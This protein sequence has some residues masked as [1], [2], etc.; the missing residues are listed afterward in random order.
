LNDTVALEI[1]GM[2][3]SY[4]GPD[5]LKDVSVSFRERQISCIIGPNGA[6]KS[7]LLRGIF[8]AKVKIKQGNVAFYGKDITNWRSEEVLRL[9]ILFIPQGHSNFP[10]MT[11][12]ENLEMGAFIRTDKNLEG[13]IES[14]LDRFPVLRER[15]NEMAGNLSGGQQKIMEIARA[16]L[17]YPK[18]M[19][20]D[21]PS[22]GL[23]PQI[24][25]L[26]FEEVKK[27]K[28][29]LTII[30]V[31]QNAKAALEVSDH[32]IVLELGKKRFEGTG[33]EIMSNEKVKKLYLGGA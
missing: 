21:E 19:L 20:M 33:K 17:L 15:Q 2:F 5:I 9:G 18:V 7:T 31:E 14:I 22:L 26:V 11:V 23:A 12:R 10:A 1:R 29:D 3:A 30:L 4:G 16:S 32:A 28:E 8:G 27:L 25:H 6:G 13:D 24:R